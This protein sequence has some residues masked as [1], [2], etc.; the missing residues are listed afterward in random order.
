M[1]NK[2]WRTFFIGGVPYRA[3]GVLRLAILKNKSWP[4]FFGK[5]QVST[6]P[7]EMSGK[8]NYFI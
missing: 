2:K 4:N 3:F 5:K 6:S 8:K 1:C 7:A